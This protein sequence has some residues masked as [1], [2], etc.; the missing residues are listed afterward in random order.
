MEGYDGHQEG[1]GL[2]QQDYLQG[3]AWWKRGILSVQ[4]SNSHYHSIQVIASR[5]SSQELFEHR[6][7][8][9]T[10]EHINYEIRS[11]DIQSNSH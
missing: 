8:I 10:K 6:F 11:I 2:W 1:P 5:S 9:V 3:L 4:V 7:S